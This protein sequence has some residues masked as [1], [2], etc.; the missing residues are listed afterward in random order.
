[1]LDGAIPARMRPRTACDVEAVS[2]GFHRK[3]DVAQRITMRIL[4]PEYSCPKYHDGGIDVT[5]NDIMTSQVRACTPRTSLASAGVALWEDDCGIL[6]VVDEQ[7]HLIGVIT[8]R[9]ICVAGA[10]KGLPLDE[11]E[12]GEVMSTDVATCWRTSTVD[13]I[14]ERMIQGRVRRLPVVDEEEEVVGIVTLNDLALRAKRRG[15]VTDG[16]LA[17]VLRGVS[18]HWKAEGPT[19]A[20]QVSAP[21]MGLVA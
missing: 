3:H 16:Q 17:E 5:A 10:T 11:I 19:E 15:G 6:P 8:D 9:D 21:E 7:R 18:R 14:V 13:E 12:V 20:V 4:S 1:M 2:A